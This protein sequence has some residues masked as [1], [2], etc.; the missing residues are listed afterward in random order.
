M[1]PLT[2]S[3]FD[4]L[5]GQSLSQD[6]DLPLY[7]TSGTGAS[8]SHFSPFSPTVESPN[9]PSIFV[10]GDDDA[11]IYPSQFGGDSIRRDTLIDTTPLPQTTYH[12]SLLNFDQFSGFRGYSPHSLSPGPSRRPVDIPSFQTINP[13]LSSPGVIRAQRSYQGAQVPGPLAPLHGSSAWAPIRTPPPPTRAPMSSQT[14][15]PP[16]PSLQPHSDPWI[17]TSTGPSIKRPDPF[18]MNW[19]YTQTSPGPWSDVEA[20]WSARPN[21]VLSSPARQRNISNAPR[22]THPPSDSRATSS[23][24]RGHLYGTSS[25]KSRPGSH[26]VAP[27]SSPA[28]PASAKGKSRAIEREPSPERKPYHP[29]APSGGSNW[30]MWVGNVPHDATQEEATDFF[31]SLSSQSLRVSSSAFRTTSTSSLTSDQPGIESIFLILQSHCAFVNYASESHLQQALAY[32]NGRPFRPGGVKLVCRVRRKAEE[33]KSG[34]G[35]Q[36]GLGLHKKWV[37]QHVRQPDSP[38][39]TA[40]IPK[41][42]DSPA[43]ITASPASRSAHYKDALD[44]YASHLSHTP[45][46]DS[47]GGASSPSVST[48]STLLATYFPVRY[49]VLKAMTKVRRFNTLLSAL[50]L[51]KRGSLTE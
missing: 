2:P 36:R 13:R 17:G 5:S 30:V 31:N 37:E 49:F 16:I 4:D 28:P 42:Q 43:I 38:A 1:S 51:T 26:G 11:F 33:I 14:W 22:P 50:N 10:P 20:A 7:P 41:F 12:D 32:F 27:H 25:S 8:T 19:Q 18:D 47:E 34:V 15:T 39:T 23:A 21:A 6:D 24:V 3:E 35:G 40:T 46:A 29:K 48:T 9:L 44:R 45:P